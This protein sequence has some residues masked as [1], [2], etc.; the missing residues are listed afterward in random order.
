MKKLK[1]RRK[2]RIIIRNKIIIRSK[3]M[4][5][6]LQK[7]IAMLVA[8]LL[9]ATVFAPLSSLA[10]DDEET[11]TYKITVTGDDLA[12]R[13]IS[14][15]KLFNITVSSDGTYT[16]DWEN[17][18]ATQG[19]FAQYVY[20]TT[21][22]SE[23]NS[24]QLYLTTAL[25]AT[26]YLKTLSTTELTALAEE[27]YTYCKNNNF[28]AV[29]TKTAEEDATSLDFTVSSIGYYLVY[30][31]TTQLFDGQAR[32]AAML[33]NVTGSAT[34]ELKADTVEVEKTADKESAEIGEKVTFTVTSEVPNLTGYD[35]YTFTV[36]DTLSK[37]LTLTTG[38]AYDDEG[39]EYTTYDVAVKIKYTTTNSETDETENVEETYTDFTVS[40]T[41]DSE[42]GETTL[43][44]AFDANKF[45]E[46]LSEKVGATI[47]ITYSATVNS[48][49]ATYNE[50]SNKVKITYSNDP[51]TDGT[52]TTEEDIVYVYTY[53][54]NFTKKNVNGDLLSGA[55]F[56]LTKTVTETDEDG[57]ETTATYY[58]K[59]DT[60]NGVSWVAS[61]T[62]ATK[63]TSGSDGTFT[64]NGLKEG[65][66]TLVEVKAPEG[67]SLPGFDGFTFTIS[68]EDTDGDGK[69]DTA[70]F[71]YIS[72]KTI[73]AATG[74]VADVTG[75]TAAFSVIVLNA[76]DGY[77]PETGG[78]GTKIFYTVGIVVMIS[79]AAVLVVRN[80]KNK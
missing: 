7:I 14:I 64:I 65:T 66:Y 71:D 27:F 44:I 18:T 69:L 21:T 46:N 79:A 49:A 36:T 23:G 26:E 9:V 8:L 10:A 54:V 42:T 3:F 57:N 33:E 56:Y 16:Y 38:T 45:V 5:T 78:I 29:D 4:K 62:D 47:E 59:Y 43:V 12:G 17:L 13:T 40:A 34:V 76:T 20:K 75:S 67:Y 2:E 1:F 6:N 39:N 68:G 53:T 37:G 48:N 11:T 32:S 25:E 80:R 30:D 61:K 58:Y 52:G 31:E 60:T 35:S 72:D 50:S 51:K 28:S 22:D 41:T 77:L 73:D 63:L 24:V 15:Y 55:E 19:F 70:T 74:Y